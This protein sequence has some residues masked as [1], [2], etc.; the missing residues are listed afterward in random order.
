MNLEALLQPTVLASLSKPG[1]PCKVTKVIESLEEPYRSAA[2][3][4][5]NR[6]FADGG[7]SEDQTAA[8]FAEAGI[9]LGH[10]TIGRHRNGWCTCPANERN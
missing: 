3:Q 2:Q 10:S 9:R 7:F 1:Q 8:K 5:A 4:L 6:T